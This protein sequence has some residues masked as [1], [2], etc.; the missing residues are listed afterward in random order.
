LK[1]EIFLLFQVFDFKIKTRSD[2]RK[3]HKPKG[4]T[5]IH[6]KIGNQRNPIFKLNWRIA[7]KWGKILVECSVHMWMHA[8]KKKEEIIYE[9][10]LPA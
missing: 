2:Q 10:T 8:F 1:F 3:K 7:D 5:Q 9:S 4:N 6:E